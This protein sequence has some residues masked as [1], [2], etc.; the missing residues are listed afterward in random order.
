MIFP[1]GFDYGDSDSFC[2]RHSRRGGVQKN[3]SIIDFRLRGN[4]INQRLLIQHIVIGRPWWINTVA[5]KQQYNTQT[6]TE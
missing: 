1:V 3:Q 5:T 6:L 2:F 4:D